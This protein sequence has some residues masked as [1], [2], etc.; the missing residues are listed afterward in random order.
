MNNPIFLENNK[1]LIEENCKEVIDIL[2]YQL[3][4]I[5]NAFYFACLIRKQNIQ[6]YKYSY[7]TKSIKKIGKLDVIS[8]HC[9]SMKYFCNPLNKQEYFF[10]INDNDEIT[11]YLIKN[12]DNFKLIQK[13]NYINNDDINNNNNILNITDDDTDSMGGGGGTFTDFNFLDVIYNQNDKNVYI[14][15]S[16]LIMKNGGSESSFDYY[17]AKSNNI[18]I[19]KDNKLNLIKNFKFDV[20]FDMNNLIYINKDSDKE[21][22][23][24]SEQTND[25][26]LI[27]LKSNYD[28]YKVENFFK[29]NNNKNQLANFIRSQCSHQSCIVYGKNNFDYLYIFCSN[30]LMIIN[31]TEKKVDKIIDEIIDFKQYYITTIHNWNNNFIIFFQ[32]E[33]LCIYD[34]NNNKIITQ[35]KK[36]KC[37]LF[38]NYSFPDKNEILG[39]FQ[40]KDK[41]E[42]YFVKN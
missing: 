33:T 1:F 31:F 7:E 4:N 11:I 8:S 37:T 41:I 9:N 32:Y 39:I 10:I 23:I 27:E 18:F 30:K 13:L 12:E 16:Y 34:I 20:D 15:I 38:Q 35:Y 2:A 21:F 3:K 36:D 25:L 19:F 17:N 5:S 6:I 28:N 22:L 24:N 26:I 14:I 40:S 29:D 42:C